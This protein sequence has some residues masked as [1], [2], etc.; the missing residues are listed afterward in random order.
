[1]NSARE[2]STWEGDL[3]VLSLSGEQALFLGSGKRAQSKA[4]CLRLGDLGATRCAAK[5]GISEKLEIHKAS[6][7]NTEAKLLGFIVPC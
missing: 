1:M 7:G 4:W 5:A 3:K 2:K 6:Q